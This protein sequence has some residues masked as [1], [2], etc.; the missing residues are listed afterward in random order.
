MNSATVALSLTGLVLA[1]QQTEVNPPATAAAVPDSMV[2]LYSKPGSLRWQCRS[3]NPGATIMFVASIVCALAT[4][5]QPRGTMSPIL[6][7]SITTSKAPSVFEAGSMTRPFLIMIL[8][9]ASQL[10]VLCS[11]EQIQQGHSDRDAIGDLVEDDR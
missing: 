1:M 7:F 4:D 9:I 10:H 3:T 11:A 5:K 2:S 6:V 8:F